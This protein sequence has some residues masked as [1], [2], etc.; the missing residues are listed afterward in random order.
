MSRPILTAILL[1]SLCAPAAA[2]TIDENGVTIY[3][4]QRTS[5]PRVTLDKKDDE[6]YKGMIPGKRDDVAHIT[7]KAAKTSA[8]NKLTWV[9]FIP[10]KRRTRI[11][12]QFADAPVYDQ[13]IASDKIVLTFSNTK[14]IEKNFMRVIDARFYKRVVKRIETKRRRGKKIVVTLFLREAAEP[15]F[16]ASGNYLY[17]DFAHTPEKSQ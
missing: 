11:F 2:Q 14:A 15:Q 8:P 7:A 1:F 5:G 9:G 10:E 16:D 6:L 12:F 4:N 3:R 17:V 13:S